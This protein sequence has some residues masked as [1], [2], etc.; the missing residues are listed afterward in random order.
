MGSVTDVG[1]ASLSLAPGPLGRLFSDK[2]GKVMHEIL[3]VGDE[4]IPPLAKTTASV[5]LT[6]SPQGGTADRGVVGPKDPLQ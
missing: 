3:N 6:E 2:G 1:A 5:T 4:M